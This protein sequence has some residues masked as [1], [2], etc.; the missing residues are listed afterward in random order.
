[1]IRI[2][3]LAD[4]ACL[5]MGVFA[6]NPGGFPSATV[7]SHQLKLGLATVRKI[8]QILSKSGLLTASRGSTG[9]YQL[10][11]AASEITLLEIVEAID[12]PLALTDCC[13]GQSCQIK[14][15]C[16]GQM[17]WRRVNE[18]VQ[19]ALQMQKLT[20]FMGGHRGSIP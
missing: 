1:M 19:R 9:G 3:K 11:R 13:S 8:L 6:R 15:E 5:I 2:S 17:G 10:A 20:D 4:Y 12:G 7:I 16:Q 14:A 18:V